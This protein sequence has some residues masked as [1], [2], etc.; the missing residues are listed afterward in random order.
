MKLEKFNILKFKSRC[1]NC[2]LL[3]VGYKFSHG[4]NNECITL[5]ENRRGRGYWPSD[6]LEYLEWKYDE[7]QSTI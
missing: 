3:P 1:L 4:L 5:G 2:G 6:N 7:S